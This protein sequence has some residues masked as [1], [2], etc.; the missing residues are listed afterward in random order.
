M[1]D[2]KSNFECFAK[3]NDSIY[4]LTGADREKF[5]NLLNISYKYPKGQE[6][7]N[8]VAF[9]GY[10]YMYESMFGVNGACDYDHKVVRLDSFRQQKDLAPILIHE[11]THIRQVERINEISNQ[12]KTTDFIGSLNAYDFIKLNRALEA[13]ACAHQAAFAYQMKE[14]YPQ[15]F[16]TEMKT[17]MMQ[18]YVGEM[19]KSGDETKAMQASFKAW[20]GYKRYQDSCEE[21]YVAQ[22]RF[23][24]TERN[25]E[26]NA[27]KKETTISNEQLTKICQHN[28]K[29]YISAAF[30][31]RAENMAVS[32]KG[33]E[34]LEQ[35]GDQSV[36]KLPV[37]GAQ[38]SKTPSPVL[39]KAAAARGR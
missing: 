26:T 35:I 2:Q 39:L 32:E 1:S 38:N 14:D 19:E 36:A 34:A 9:Q 6:T 3:L 28:G 37:R 5:S 16:E 17:P 10:S 27:V 25:K 33:K 8:A 30:F 7:L 21:M 20:Y 11:C 15:V 31:D 12:K 18:A 23:N 22:I 29:P 24:A 4:A 13:D